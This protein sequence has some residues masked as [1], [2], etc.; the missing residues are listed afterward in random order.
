[1]FRFSSLHTG[2]ILPKYDDRAINIRS[3]VRSG[4]P[5]AARLFKRTEAKSLRIAIRKYERPLWFQ[6]QCA[7]RWRG[8]SRIILKIRGQFT[9]EYRVGP[10]RD[11]VW[12]FSPS[13]IRQPRASGIARTRRGHS[14]LKQNS[15][16]R[17]ALF[18][19]GNDTLNLHPSTALRLNLP[20]N[21]YI[22]NTC[23]ICPIPRDGRITQEM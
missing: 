21:R 6:G 7:V 9:L 1:M 10:G 12:T 22:L 17:T 2:S 4:S 13:K 14:N 18:I 3:I 23:E 20:N 15:L 11:V 16:T 5:V 8:G 19:C